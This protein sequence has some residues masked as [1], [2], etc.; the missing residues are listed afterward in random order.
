MEERMRPSP[1]THHHFP[2][3][4]TTLMNRF[5]DARL[6][7]PPALEGGVVRVSWGGKFGRKVGKRCISKSTRDCA[8][9]V[10]K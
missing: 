9:F 6:G 5:I 1:I 10:L 3:M 8:K 2:Q 4:K 7:G